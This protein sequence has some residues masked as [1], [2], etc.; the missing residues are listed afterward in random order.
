MLSEKEL[1]EIE[2]GLRANY[3]PSWAS[4]SITRLLAEVRRLNRVIADMGLP[5]EMRNPASD[6]TVY[7]PVCMRCGGLMDSEGDC[8]CAPPHPF[9]EPL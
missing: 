8:L 9:G 6:G 7:A 4:L 5:D 3:K 2:E 1:R